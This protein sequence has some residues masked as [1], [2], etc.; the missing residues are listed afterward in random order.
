ML[1]ISPFSQGGFVCRDRFDHTSTLRFLEARF[2]VEV[3]NLA[4]WRRSVTGDLT[5]AFNFAEPIFT[6]P[7]LPPA[8]PWV[9]AQHPECATEES[10]MAPSPTPRAQHQSAQEPGHRPSPSGLRRRDGGD[11]LSS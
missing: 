9:A 2:G 3:P 4:E 5:G 8:P 6:P 10:T 1:V 11:D 7:Q